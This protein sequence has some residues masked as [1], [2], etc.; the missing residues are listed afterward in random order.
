VTG[1]IH[2]A[3]TKEGVLGESAEQPPSRKRASAGDLTAT[4]LDRALFGYGWV[5]VPATAI[6]IRA[7][8]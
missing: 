3:L 1:S 6:S 4:A 2:P 7:N 5:I 8:A